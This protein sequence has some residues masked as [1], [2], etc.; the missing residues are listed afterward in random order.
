MKAI[1]TALLVLSAGI[2]S[3]KNAQA[4]CKGPKCGGGLF[5]CVAIKRPRNKAVRMYRRVSETNRN[6][7]LKV[8]EQLLKIKTNSSCFNVGE[9]AEINHMKG[10]IAL[11]I[12]KTWSRVCRPNGMIET[13]IVSCIADKRMDRMA[14]MTWL[15]TALS[16]AQ[17][18]KRQRKQFRDS[19][20]NKLRTTKLIRQITLENRYI[21]KKNRCIKL[22]PCAHIKGPGRCFKK[23]RKACSGNF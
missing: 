4:G 22:Q 7:L 23:W 5:A 11:M 16:R 21:V 14:A 1:I 15:H 8:R 9:R 6:Q 2:F 3:Q 17:E 13:P 18:A 10:W 20:R 19:R 12:G